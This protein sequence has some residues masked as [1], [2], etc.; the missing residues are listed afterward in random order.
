MKKYVAFIT[1]LLLVKLSSAQYSLL[2]C[3]DVN[4]EG[5][6]VAVSNQ[7]QIDNEGGVL[8]L[9]ARAEDTFKVDALD[10]RI[11][12]VSDGGNEEELVRLPQTIQ[13]DWTFAWKETVIFDPGLYRVKIYTDKGTYLTSSNV[14]IRPR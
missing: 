8:K 4:A 13:P 7:F 5:K 14:T 6:P 10:F 3:E 9:L 2:F 12:Y 11:Y 1:L